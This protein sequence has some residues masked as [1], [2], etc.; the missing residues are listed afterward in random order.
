MAVTTPQG[1]RESSDDTGHSGT[2]NRRARRVPS[3]EARMMAPAVIVL[4]V[5][6][7]VP[8]LFMIVMSFTRITLIGGIEFHWNGLAN[9]QQ[10]F[11]DPLVWSSWVRAMLYFVLTV[12]IEM[13][14]GA[15]VA[16]AIHELVWGRNAVLSLALL[17][18]F[19]APVVVGMLGRFLTDPTYGLYSWV[20]SSTGIYEGNVLGSPVPAFASVVLMNVWEWTPLITLIV[21]AGLTAVPQGLVEAASIDGASYWQRLRHVVWPTVSGIV[22]IALLVRSMDAIRYF[23]IIWISTNGGPANA[24]KIIPLRLYEVAFRFFDIGYAATIGLGMLA[25]SILVANAFIAVLRRREVV[26]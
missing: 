1:S 15:A 20:L 2:R 18:M 8:F 12:G 13:V 6:T 22:L 25:F 16:L 14:L 17:P 11:T 10:M 5:I 4:A 9:W 19:I 3:F 23:A 21:L 7:F 26:R 24:T